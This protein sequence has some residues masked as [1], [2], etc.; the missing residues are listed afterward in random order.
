MIFAAYIILNRIGGL[1]IFNSFPQ[2]ESGM[3]YGMLFLIG[4]LTSVHCVG[5]CGGINISQCLPGNTQSN[6]VKK[7]QH[8]LRPGILYNAGRIASYTV[9][10]GFVGGIGSFISFSGAA[11]GIVQLAAGVFMI[12]MGLNMLN[13]FP[14]LRKITPKMPKVFINKKNKQIKSTGPFYVGLLNGL[15]PCGPLQAMQIYALSTG[16]PFKGALS[17]FLFSLGTTPLMF[18]LGSL[19]AY[20]SKKYTVKILKASA[21]LVVV[22]GVVMLN[23]GMSLSGFTLSSISRPGGFQSGNFAVIEND[24]Q[25]VTSKMFPG[26]YEPITVQKG[27]PVNWTIKAEQGDINGCN[28]S[29]IVPAYDLGKKLEPGDNIIEFFPDETGEIVFSCWMG[30]IRS[31]ISVV[32]DL[33][34][35]QPDYEYSEENGNIFTVLSDEIVVAKVEG[36]IQYVETDVSGSGFK[37]AIIVVE[38]GLET[39]WIINAN[40]TVDD[41][42]FIVVP[43]YNARVELKQGQNIIRFDPRE[44]FGF[45]S[46]DF[47]YSGYVKV[48]DDINDIRIDSIISDTEAYFSQGFDN[49]ELTCH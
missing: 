7:G 48:V 8:T 31:R 9:I 17:M 18:G 15:M 19:S 1:S 26:R 10:G 23:S 36:D 25:I 34:S 49:E 12:I 6:I 35:V 33:D 14:W 41:E 28:N 16:D 38:R 21:V 2:A 46:G 42:I 45:V 30:M 24:L 4:L 3:G 43:V 47:I 5:M 29:I 32:D 13:I 11:R 20:L 39:L 27:I 40:I 22:L 44:D 37:P